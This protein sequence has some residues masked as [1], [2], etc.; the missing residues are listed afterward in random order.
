MSSLI[1]PPEGITITAVDAPTYGDIYHIQHANGAIEASYYQASRLYEVH[2]LDVDPDKRRLGIGT[3]LLRTG[4]DHAQI[5]G[6]SCITASIISRECLQVMENVFGP[7]GITVFLRGEF[8]ADDE[9]YSL[10]SP[11]SAVLRA[12]L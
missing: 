10:V 6:A 8:A 2:S 7:D 4:R 5:L 3:L 11:T 9:N 12:R 1:L